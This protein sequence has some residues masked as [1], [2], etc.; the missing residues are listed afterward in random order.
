MHE[1]L[2][3]FANICDNQVNVAYVNNG[4]NCNSNPI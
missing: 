4:L 1:F 3:D 2:V